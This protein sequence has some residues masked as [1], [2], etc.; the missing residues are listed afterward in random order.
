M[1]SYIPNVTDKFADPALYTPNFGFLDTML[2][3]R[4]SM[5]DQGFAQV[6]K[7][8]ATLSREVTNGANAENRDKY[9]Q[10]AQKQLKN[11][12][13]LDLSQQ[14]NVQ[15]ATN[16]FQ[17]FYKDQNLLGDMALTAHYNQ[18]ESIAESFRLKDGGKQFS[19]KNLDLVRMQRQ[20]FAQDSAD[21]WRKYMGT[22]ESYT[23]YYDYAKERVEL[24]SKFVPSTVKRSWA[25]G[26]GYI[27]T[28]E[29]SS[30]YK[31]EVQAYLSANMSQQAKRQM[32]I[33][34]IV[35]YSRSPEI[36]K[37]YDRNLA[38]GE[39][40]IL[41]Q[42]KQL[43]GLAMAAKTAEE[44]EQFK[45]KMADLNDRLEDVRR[46][47]AQA[48]DPD[49][50]L[51]NRKQIAAKLYSSHVMD[52][53]AESFVRERKSEELSA[54]QVYLTRLQIDA[55]DRRAALDREN[56]KLLK[57]VDIGMYTF[58]TRGNL[59]RVQDESFV[60]PTGTMKEGSGYAKH[61][62]E[63]ATTAKEEASAKQFMREYFYNSNPTYRNSNVDIND[64][65]VTAGLNEFIRQQNAA[66][67]SSDP[68]VQKNLSREFLNYQERMEGVNMRKRIIQEREDQ[69]NSVLDKEL[70]NI[71]A[72]IKQ[73]WGNKET[74]VLNTY[75]EKTRTY[76]PV[77]VSINDF[78]RLY[79]NSSS[80][81]ESG[82]YGPDSKDY[83]VKDGGLKINI[84]GR[85]AQFALGAGAPFKDA[86]SI[87][88]GNNDKIQNVGSTYNKMFDKAYTVNDQ[89]LRPVNAKDPLVVAA[90]ESI[91]NATGV[92]V[93]KI[94]ID[95]YRTGEMR[96]RFAKDVKPENLP[97]E[98]AM[99][100]KGYTR[101][102]GTGGDMIYSVKSGLFNPRTGGIVYSPKQQA[103]SEFFRE[104]KQPDENNPA[105]V[106]STPTGMISVNQGRNPIMI[107]KTSR[108]GQ[109]DYYDIKD[110]QTGVM[111]NKRA[112][113]LDQVFESMNIYDANPGAIDKIRNY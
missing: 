96:V 86:F 93:N 17:P 73:A 19:Q 89:Y 90:K 51:A 66:A 57:M 38:D 82:V 10:S 34:G 50:Q 100:A 16:I 102:Q 40:F 71:K 11:L 21:S 6:N 72:Q 99:T 69:A 9:L 58:D 2:R 65:R 107:I 67:K 108:L 7:E 13:S 56:N 61:Q 75:D 37:E 98:E 5:Y 49:Y 39:K 94:F 3:R 83:M 68:K 12:S 29:D 36:F 18:Q 33:E 28:V 53:A 85:M 41:H 104:V 42:Q 44:K 24:M 43:S 80:L 70:G 79:K 59:V 84:N 64:D 78:I 112:L 48:Q 87:L 14:Q 77:E 27:H 62:Q 95:G 30:I 91:A 109:P 81:T 74:Q 15:N 1:A 97:T 92:D 63:K 32:E 25:D 22:K 23:P 20:E 4:Q 55:A 60:A 47:R 101:A 105:T 111:L 31:Q 52:V 110:E 106:Y 76:K 54:D 113:T 88:K 35:D 26:K 46:A 103:V 8:Y 45:T